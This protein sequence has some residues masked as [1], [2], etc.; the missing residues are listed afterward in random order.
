[1]T[2]VLRVAVFSDIHAGEASHG[3]TYVVTE[4]PASRTN[5]N[6]LRDLFALA[7]RTGLHADVVLCPGDLGNRAHPVGRMYGWGSLQELSSALSCKSL[8]ATVGNHDVE[9]RSSSPDQA[10]LLKTLS[11]TYPVNDL[12]A[13]EAY[14]RDGFYIDDSDPQYRILNLNT[15]AD[16]P[17]FPG[18]HTPEEIREEHRL[19]VERGAISEA[20][21]AAIEAALAP[22]SEKTVNIALM[23]HHP[24]EHARHDLLKDTYGPAH[25][26]EKFLDVLESASNCGRWMVVHGH[27]HI[28][29]FTVD[30]GS[31]Q[32]PLVLCAASVGGHLWQP[33]AAIARNQFHII[34]FELD[35]VLG[36]PI[37][38]GR[39]LTWAWSF[40][41]GWTEAPPTT[42]LPAEF[43]F[44]SLHD[45]KDLADQVAD[46]FQQS[47]AEYE[48]WHE[49]GTAIPSIRYLG[50]RDL[51]LF[52]DRLESAGLVLERNRSFGITSVARRAVW[53]A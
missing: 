17:P 51:E 42:G 50:P 52:E 2:E 46:R 20:R 21:L 23:H 31:A 9:T 32:S 8:I 53:T 26:G 33:I 44:G 35:R 37:T 10:Q 41:V 40:G 39:V 30:G 5:E 49:V 43:G 19:I 48:R 11:P 47:G 3:D 18:E 15:C 12:T 16:F 4:P 29:N 38:R 25:N 13:A 22:L 24:V 6:P 7:S 34:E 28:P 45:P 36:L 27:K 14:W 1:M